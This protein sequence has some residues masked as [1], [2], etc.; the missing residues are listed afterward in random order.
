MNF[1]RIFILAT[2]VLF[3]LATLRGQ[4]LEFVIQPHGTLDIAADALWYIPLDTAESGYLANG[5][6]ARVSS[7]K[8]AVYPW[9]DPANFAPDTTNWSIN[10]IWSHEF[11]RVTATTGTLGTQIVIPYRRVPTDAD[12]FITVTV[13]DPPAV[14]SIDFLDFNPVTHFDPV[15]WKI[16]FDEPVSGVTEAN[17]DLAGNLEGE[18]GI[19]EVV[20]VEG[21]NN[22]V[23]RVTASTGEGTGL[24]RLDWAG[25]AAESP[26]VP[27]PFTGPSYDFAGLPVFLEN[28]EGGMFIVHPDQPGIP[29]SGLAQTRATDTLYYQ[30][31][32]HDRADHTDGSP[33]R[34]DGETT[35]EFTVTGDDL[36][37]DKDSTWFILI[38]STNA[39]PS[40]PGTFPPNRASTAAEI[41][42]VEPPE[43]GDISPDAVIPQGADYQIH[44]FPAG[45]TE[46]LVFEWFAGKSGDT[47]Q[48]LSGVNAPFLHLTNLTDTKRFWMRLS[49][50]AG[51]EHA[52][53]S[54]TITVHVFSGVRAEPTTVHTLPG[55][56]IDPG[57]RF[58]LV[59]SADQPVPWPGQMPLHLRL[60][61]GSGGAGAV[62]QE[63]GGTQ[64]AWQPEGT[65]PMEIPAMVANETTGSHTLRFAL[66]NQFEQSVTLWNLEARQLWRNLHYGRRD[67]AGDAADIAAP[68]GDG[69]ANLLKYAL[70]IDPKDPSRPTVRLDDPAG[71]LP[72]VY[73]EEGRLHVVFTRLREAHAD[74]TYRVTFSTDLVTWEEA[75][76]LELVAEEDALLPGGGPLADL[77]KRVHYRGPDDSADPRQF[78]R[79]EV[80]TP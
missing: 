37:A 55:R 66:P 23:W 40:D 80:S 30:W 44:A 71:G 15:S 79:V 26:Q 76:D 48:P 60:V 21:E 9:G 6:I 32:R 54:P 62:F 25:T 61:P 36:L 53:H 35:P 63:S 70:A 8:I 73:R 47:S 65:G 77:Y 22:R 16:I 67:N 74:V 13:A 31:Y 41:Q 51:L 69:I 75:P 49:N 24:L 50:A 45:G 59:D 56:V 19:T 38:A 72:L 43:L 2:L 17:F 57:P 3:S 1:V 46:P 64:I 7:N 18:V 78:A 27:V 28:P 11:L 14:S 20:P 58:T 34:L 52:A 5:S 29:L 10:R 68:L 33:E 4:N 42:R 12:S 39:F